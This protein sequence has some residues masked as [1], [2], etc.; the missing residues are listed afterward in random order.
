[1]EVS[2]EID[3]LMIL[4]PLAIVLLLIALGVVLMYQQ[5]QKNIISQQLAKEALKGAH[6]KE[7]L[8]M[9]VKT[10]EEERKRIAR[11]LHDELGAALSIA[12]MQ[13]VQLENQESTNPQQITPIRE[14][15]E[16]TLASTRRI[17]HELMPLQLEQLGLEKA[18]LSLLKGAET[19]NGLTTNLAV[20]KVCNQIPWII[21]LGLYRIYS[22]LINNTLKHSGAQT[23]DISI[24]CEKN[25]LFCRYADDGKGIS[26]SNKTT[27]LGMQ[28]IENRIKALNGSWEYES[29]TNCG[30]S[31]TIK[32]ITTNE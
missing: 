8:H 24:L 2:Q 1:M 25:R 16:T 17:S 6:Q 23:I 15:M 3:F 13:L 4:L 7:L 20:S 10:Q 22:E 27:G 31:A 12:R 29:Q 26:K 30:F 19:S 32:I 9:I 11:D 21:E 5:F 28:S 14:L 18:I